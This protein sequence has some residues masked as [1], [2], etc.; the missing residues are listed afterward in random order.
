MKHLSGWKLRVESLRD[1]TAALLLACRH[2]LTPWYAKALAVC[3]VAYL[4][5]PID[6]IPDPIPILGQLDD[7]L[8]VPLGIMAVRALIPT[9][10]LE[11]S[12]IKAKEA[13]I[14]A[15]RW[16]WAMAGFIVILWIFTVWLIVAFVRRFL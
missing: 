10:I 12:R 7:L 11:E 15:P 2:P 16:R 5:C 1:E 13:M 6:L 8:I 9:R 3:V 14:E 4:F